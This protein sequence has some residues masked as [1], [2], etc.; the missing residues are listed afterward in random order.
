MSD[1]VHNFPVHVFSAALHDENAEIER[2]HHTDDAGP[3]DGAEE[4]AS[5]SWNEGSNKALNHSVNVEFSAELK[6]HIWLNL[7]VID[8]FVTNVIDPSPRPQILDGLALGAEE[9]RDGYQVP[10]NKDRE[11]FNFFTVFFF[12]NYFASGLRSRFRSEVDTS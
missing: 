7:I 11:I 2:L 1:S 6:N 10:E 4:A 3:E 12:C 5:L 8:N 9:H